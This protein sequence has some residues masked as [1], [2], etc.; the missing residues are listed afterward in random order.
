MT[1][2]P[3]LTMPQCRG[4]ALFHRLAV[5]GHRVAVVLQPSL[6]LRA[7][8]KPGSMVER[9]QKPPCSAAEEPMVRRLSLGE[10]WIRTTG[11]YPNLKSSSRGMLRFIDIVHTHLGAGAMVQPFF[12]CAW[13]HWNHS[14]EPGWGTF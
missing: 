1:T 8:D 14:I 10:S 11:S 2:S 4:I 7:V 12:C 13:N 9:R 5:P 6:T 3:M